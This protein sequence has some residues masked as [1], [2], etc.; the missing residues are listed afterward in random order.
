MREEGYLVEQNPGGKPTYLQLTTKGK[1]IAK[2]LNF[3][4]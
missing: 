4:S 1:E 3:L 2:E